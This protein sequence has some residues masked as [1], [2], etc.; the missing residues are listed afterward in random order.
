MV[1]I[2]PPLP[3]P[4]RTLDGRLAAAENGHD[5]DR[6][7]T[8]SGVTA[9]ALVADNDAWEEIGAAIADL[10]RLIHARCATSRLCN[11]RPRIDALAAR[12]SEAID[13]QIDAAAWRVIDAAA[14]RRSEVAQ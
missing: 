9:R 13:D 14:R 5:A 8:C 1:T 4:P 6:R 2:P 11:A 12:V 3:I 10:A 7:S